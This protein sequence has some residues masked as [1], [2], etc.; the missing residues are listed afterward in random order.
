[1]KPPHHRFPRHLR[2]PWP[3]AGC[4]A[5]C[6]SLGAVGPSP[7]RAQAEAGPP[8]AL[9]LPDVV[10]RAP[11]TTPSTGEPTEAPT[12]EVAASFDALP[13][14]RLREAGPGLQLSE[15]LVAVPGVVALNRQNPAQDLQLSIRGF[16]ARSPFG[17]RGVRLYED[18][19]PLSTPDGQGQTSTFD[20]GAAQR[21]EVLR[22][23]A[24]VLHGNAAG[25]VVQLFGA[26]AP[27]RPEARLGLVAGPDGLW[28]A[29]AEAGGQAGALNLSVRAVGQEAS[30]HRE[31]SASSRQQWRARLSWRFDAERDWLLLASQLRLPQA[32]D[33]LGLSAEQVATHPRQA[34]SGA[35]AYDTRKAIQQGQF[36]VVHRWRVGSGEW[37]VMAHAGQREVRQFQAIP[38]PPDGTAQT[39]PTHPGGVIDLAREFRGLDV[40]HSGRGSWLARPLQ[41]TGGWS[42]DE[43]RERR[44]GFQNFDASGRLGVV[45]AL[46]RDE[47]N[48]ARNADP[49]LQAQWDVAPDWQLGAGLRHSHVRFSSQD[50]YV[51]AGNGD[52]SGGLRFRATTP[53]AS[54]RWRVTPGWHV[55][56]A[57]G[58]SF[59][60]PTLN[61]VAYRSVS[62]EATGWNRGLRAAKGVQ[63][64]LGSKWRGPAGAQLDAALFQVRTQDEIAVAQNAFGRSVFQNAGSTERIGLEVSARARLAAD[65]V[66]GLTGQLAAAWTRATHLD[67]FRSTSAG[68]TSGV[69]AGRALP[70]VPR[71]TAFAEVV[72]RPTAAGWLGWPGWHMALEWRHSGRIWANDVNDAFA[73]ASQSWSWRLGWRRTWVDEE[74]G[75]GASGGGAWR[76]DALLRIDNLLDARNVGSVIVNEGSRRYFE[77][78]PG[79]GVT[80]TLGLARVF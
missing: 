66:D 15:V 17:V 45:G 79:R 30:G 59:E 74:G 38:A 70:G 44:Q 7:A 10:V 14:S 64:E 4:L 73:P 19:I 76:L 57:A 63:L 18:G 36:G 61:E 33:P 11:R 3:G 12:L 16:G 22:G 68:V 53:V 23:P 58:R 52:D 6:L 51:V 48:A 54:V 2:T 39:R 55:H 62:G 71:R 80:V 41:W 40:R 13:A 75:G 35:L 26:D 9:D 77:S 1:M 67:A 42:F 50:R 27:P 37:R 60:T 20:L 72:W 5:A 56:A 43:V 69:A 21:V 31:H 24:S 65:R 8:A 47:D 25:G 49:Y 28:Q 46:R 34:G 32:Q 78:A 29:S